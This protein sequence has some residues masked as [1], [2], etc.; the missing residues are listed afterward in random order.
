MSART[1]RPSAALTVVRRGTMRASGGARPAPTLA[2]APMIRALTVNAT[3][4]PLPARVAG[5]AD[6]A[7]TANIAN[8]GTSMPMSTR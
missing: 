1:G 2:D 5:E 7:E 4:G 6:V 8:T 3:D